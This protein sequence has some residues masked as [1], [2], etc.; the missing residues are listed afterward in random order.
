MLKADKLTVEAGRPAKKLKRG[1]MRHV[2][3]AFHW[4]KDT[5]DPVLLEAACAFWDALEA[6][7]EGGGYSRDSERVSL[8]QRKIEWKA[9]TLKG[10][11]GDMEKQLETEFILNKRYCAVSIAKTSDLE[12]KFNVKV[13]S[14]LAQCDPSRKN[15]KDRFYLVI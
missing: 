4:K 1:T 11:N 7:A 13:A 8:L 2:L 12:S 15:M 14:D 3:Q 9:I 5:A 10:W 6:R